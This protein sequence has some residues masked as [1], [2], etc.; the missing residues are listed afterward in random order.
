MGGG[1]FCPNPTV[2]TET[3]VGIVEMGNIL[4]GCAAALV[5]AEWGSK[6]RNGAF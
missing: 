5:N 2:M 3:S 4:G 6:Q 1:S